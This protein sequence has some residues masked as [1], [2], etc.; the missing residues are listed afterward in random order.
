[1]ILLNKIGRLFYCVG[2]IA[3]G[4]QQ[5]ISKKFR[6]EILSPFPEWPHKYD[7]FPILTGLFLIYI[8]AFISGVF[9]IKPERAKDACIYFGLWFLTLCVIS[10]LPYILIFSPHSALRLDVWFGIG[11][12]F[13]YSGGAFAMAGSFSNDIVDP[14]RNS[15]FQLLSEKLIS[16]GRIFYSILMLIF[17]GSHFVFTDFVSSMVPKW[18]GVPLFWTYFVGVALLLSACAMIFKIWIRLGAFLLAIMLFLFLIF[19]HVPEAIAN[20][21]PDGNEILRSFVALLFCGIAVVI[22]VTNGRA[23]NAEV[24]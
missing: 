18:I 13:A 23:R 7:V 2:I 17:A 22:A 21:G 9:K 24:E 6:S 5:L 14:W 11:E 20:P 4:V 1:M 16:S 10:H 3:L 19:F 8:G 12:A 15:G